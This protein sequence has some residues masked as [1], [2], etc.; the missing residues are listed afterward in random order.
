VV[1][2]ALYLAA[3]AL[4]YAELAVVASAA[5]LAVLGGVAWTHPRP[6]LTVLREVTPKTVGRGDPAVGVVTVS[7]SGRR[8]RSQSVVVDVVGG[9][10]VAVELPALAPGR[11][12]RVTYRLPTDRRGRVPVGPL[13]QVR[14]DPA[15]LARRVVSWGG[16]ESLLV[17]P[18]VHALPMLPVGRLRQL[19]GSTSDAALNGTATF[20]SLREYVPG[21]DLRHVHWRS[22]ARVGTL[23]TREL[24]DASRPETT[25]VLDLDPETYGD[26]AGA[27]DPFELAVEA[28]ASIAIA[29]ARHGHPV[30]ILA[31]WGP[32]LETRGRG[33]TAVVLDR[34]ALVAP[35]GGT[36]VAAALEGLRRSR[37]GGLLVVVSGV[38]DRGAL[39]RLRL[40]RDRFERV[41]TVR[42]GAGQA[43]R[44]AV[45]AL[46]VAGS[47]E[48]LVAGWRREA[49]R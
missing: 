45:G 43:P 21:D 4:G 19:E 22:S 32:A 13:R 39:D 14:E 2:A 33:G 41:V 6:H 5:A 44:P 11:G 7:N 20:H 31:G 17:R 8:W 26:A 16:V 27:V 46:V 12:R 42:L 30:R 37:A 49:A 24:V 29:A 18:R 9:T 40:L 47:Q 10:E 1:S 28:A 25:I 35:E 34:L 48:E 15:G 23:V 36:A 38:R 3:V